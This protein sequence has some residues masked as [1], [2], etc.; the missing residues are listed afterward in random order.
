MTYNQLRDL[1]TAADAVWLAYDR[2]FDAWA[3]SFGPRFVK[4]GRAG[5]LE[6]IDAC[7]AAGAPV[8][9]V[10]DQADPDQVYIAGSIENP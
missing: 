8:P 1:V 3:N 10:H 9:T 6:V 5:A 2:A 4:V 7:Q